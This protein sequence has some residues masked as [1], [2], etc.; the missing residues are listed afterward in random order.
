MPLVS[1]RSACV[2]DP[3]EQGLLMG[4]AAP[5][6]AS[7]PTRRWGLPARFSFAGTAV[8]LG[9]VAAVGALWRRGLPESPAAGSGRAGLPL[10]QAEGRRR[11]HPEHLAS[12][13]WATA[14]EL[15][16]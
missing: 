9:L 3:D 7:G 15:P 5:S 10:I 11:H 8:A 12:L 16:R 2:T 4:R 13:A 6:Q 14:Q 1:A